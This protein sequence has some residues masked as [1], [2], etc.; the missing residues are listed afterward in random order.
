MSAL[1][2][3]SGGLGR[4]IGA[5]IQGAGTAGEADADLLR[6]PLT[7]IRENPEQPRRHFDAEALGELEAS[8]RAHGVLV[9]ILVREDADRPGDYVLIAGERRLRAARA[10]GLAVI[11]ALVRPLRGPAE[12]LE[13]ALI[14]NLQRRDL[15]PIEAALGYAALRDEHGYDQNQLAAAVG[16]ARP[17]I[18]NA[19]RLLELEAPI[20]D[21][22]SDGTITAGHGRALLGLPAGEARL[23]AFETV[24]RLGL[25]V[26]ATESM[27]R[28]A[29]EA[30]AAAPTAAPLDSRRLGT[31]K[32]RL[33][34][35]LGLPVRVQTQK[36]GGARVTLEIAD[37]D[38]LEALLARLG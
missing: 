19:L 14:E 2:K 34:K 18:S 7:A 13:L 32:R 16:L 11:P 3:R 8:V 29:L 15:D 27:V 21:A 37:A 10:A 23:A 24:R 12:S 20:R 22:I 30:P 33:G 36:E 26:R 28:H 17:T 25:S 31:M 5:L 38:A 1:G 6:V 4:G 35:R 9:P